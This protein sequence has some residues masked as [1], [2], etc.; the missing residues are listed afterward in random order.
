MKKIV[1]LTLLL[2]ISLSGCVDTK[3][4]KQDC[5]R[6][7]IRAN[8][9]SEIDQSVKLDVRDAVVNYL[10]PLLSDCKSSDDAKEVIRN[11]L[12]ALK[13]TSD[14]VL[15]DK[16]FPYRATVRLS[17]EKFP[18]RKYDDVSFPA[19]VYDALIV[20]LGEGTGNNW[21]C[22]CFPPLCFVPDDGSENFRYKSKIVE[23]IK[24]SE[25]KMN[26]NS[27]KILCAFVLFVTMLTAVL[28]FSGVM[29]KDD[30]VT[31]AVVLK[32][33]STGNQVKTVQTKLKR[34]G[35]YTGAVDGIYGAATTKAVKYFQSKNGLTADGIVGK[36]TAAAMG[37]SLSTGNAT[38]SSSGYSSSDEYLLAKCV[39]AEARGEPYVGQVAVAAVVLNRV[40]SASFPNTIAGVIYQP[41][42]FTAVNDGQINLSPNAT[43]IKAAKDALNGWDPTNGCLYY[44]NP[45]TATSKWIWSRTVMLSIGKHNFAK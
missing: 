44:Y 7:H 4:R 19:G 29:T 30:A 26:K 45:S 35:Y 41:W 36:K 8:S 6:I 31:E 43:A 20:E 10:T 28:A 11:N 13:K 18:Y 1:I 38:G 34:W 42:A 9:N 23:I 15:L 21:W 37:I 40:K 12:C 5:V 14:D 32:Q 3:N 27:Q 24:N 39:Y 17:E 33:G 16:G 2:M 22:V 25:V